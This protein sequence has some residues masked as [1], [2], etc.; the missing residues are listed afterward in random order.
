L[1]RLSRRI[2]TLTKFTF[3]CVAGADQNKLNRHFYTD[4]MQMI[5]EQVA[6]ARLSWFQQVHVALSS[7]HLADGYQ[8]VHDMQGR[9]DKAMSETSALFAQSA[10]KS[11]EQMTQGVSAISVMKDVAETIIDTNTKTHE[12]AQKMREALEA[13]TRETQELIKMLEDTTFVGDAKDR[14]NLSKETLPPAPKA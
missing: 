11:R 12:H 10:K 14:A 1:A 13:Q 7:A 5:D 3:K 4:M 9:T 8:L 6:D 2:D